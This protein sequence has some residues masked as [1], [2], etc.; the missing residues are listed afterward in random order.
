MK[1]E[2]LLH[3]ANVLSQNMNFCIL[4]ADDANAAIWR[5]ILGQVHTL[6]TRAILI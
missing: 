3:E 2:N 6:R 4:K 1:R 5:I